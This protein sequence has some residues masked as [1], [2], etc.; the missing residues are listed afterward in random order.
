MARKRKQRRSAERVRALGR[1]VEQLEQLSERMLHIVKRS[2]SAVEQA[3][4]ALESRQADESGYLHVRGIHVV[5]AAGDPM[6]SISA[7]HSG[8]A[9]VIRNGAGKEIAAIGSDENGKGLVVVKDPAGRAVA[10]LQIRR[11]I[12]ELITSSNAGE[13]CQVSPGRPA[14]R[15]AE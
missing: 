3:C 4:A 9:I 11:S 6:V 2:E 15:D 14:G 8:G 7:R 5:N 10:G 13:I 1:R 12:G